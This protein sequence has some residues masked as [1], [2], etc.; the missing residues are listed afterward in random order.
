MTENEK[1]VLIERMSDNLKVLR[2]SLNLSQEQLALLLGVSRYTIM[3]IETGKRKMTWN[4]FL[5]LI[6][7]FSK[8]KKTD[9]MLDM[10][11]IYTDELNTALK[12][13]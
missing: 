9:K 5:S 4:T 11:E 12:L 1:Q 8:N 7:V 10:F 3:S 2:M 13:K 6:L